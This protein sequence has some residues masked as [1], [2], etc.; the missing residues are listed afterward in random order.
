MLLGVVWEASGSAGSRFHLPCLPPF[1]LEEVSW[2]EEVA[3][4]VHIDR[5]AHSPSSAPPPFILNTP[6]AT[7]I[8]QGLRPV[9]R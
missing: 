7:I 6:L 9:G 8:S 4:F 2:L 1:T 5:A 3:W